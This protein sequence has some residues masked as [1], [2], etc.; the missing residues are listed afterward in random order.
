MHFTRNHDPRLSVALDVFRIDGQMVAH[1]IDA[2]PIGFQCQ[3]KGAQL[4]EVQQI[5]RW[6]WLLSL[7]FDSS[8]GPIGMI[9]AVAITGVADPQRQTLDPRRTTLTCLA[10]APARITPD[11][12]STFPS[13]ALET[14]PNRV[15]RRRHPRPPRVETLGRA[16]KIEGE[17]PHRMCANP[18]R[19]SSTAIESGAPLTDLS[20]CGEPQP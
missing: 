10:G 4:A 14:S 1:R 16:V 12:Q 9:H 8:L 5:R 13:P 6:S 3:I 11:S 7:A 17:F 2:A 15:L 19:K 20:T 18:V